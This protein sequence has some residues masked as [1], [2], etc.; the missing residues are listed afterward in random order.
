LA[1]DEKLAADLWVKSAKLV[2]L[3]AWDPFT[4]LDTTSGM[5]DEVSRL[6]RQI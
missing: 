5:V 1:F 2:G 4:A 3:G 6:S